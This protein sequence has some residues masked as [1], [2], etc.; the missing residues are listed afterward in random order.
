MSKPARIERISA[1]FLG[2][3]VAAT[4]GVTC[5]PTPLAASVV[6]QVDHRVEL[7]AVERLTL[8][9]ALDLDHEAV[10]RHDH[11]GVDLCADV[12]LVGQV[13]ARLPVDDADGHGRD[14]VSIGTGDPEIAKGE[15]ECHP[16][17]GDRG[18]PGAAVGLEHV[19]VDREGPLANGLEVD[20]G[21]QRPSDEPLDLLGAP[22]G[23]VAVTARPLHTRA[24][25]HG[26]LGGE[27]ATPWFPAGNP[28]LDVGGADH[29]GRPERDQH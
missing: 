7:V 23:A 18:S 3:P 25:E 4:T 15:L 21:P 14:L 28:V 1:S 16:T 10:A 9:R 12:L 24:G 13:E 2:L 17:T 5:R 29:A 6:R 8:G 11:V 22:A 19:A 27:P 20:R 26:V